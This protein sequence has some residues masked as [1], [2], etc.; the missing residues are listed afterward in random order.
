MEEEHN[1]GEYSKFSAQEKKIPVAVLVLKSLCLGN[2]LK[3][4][5]Y[6]LCSPSSAGFIHRWFMRSDMQQC[7]CL[8]YYLFFFPAIHPTFC[9]HGHTK[10]QL[11]FEKP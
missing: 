8:V 3:T 10:A 7:Y 9:S 11:C 2:L 6:C 4:R 1:H 5:L